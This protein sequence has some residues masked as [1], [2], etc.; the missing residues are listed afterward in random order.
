MLSPLYSQGKSNGTQQIRGGVNQVT[1]DTVD[2][3]PCHKSCLACPDE[4][5]QTWPS[6]HLSVQFL[7]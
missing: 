3:P 5:T 2:V 4:G 1:V 7:I 6:M